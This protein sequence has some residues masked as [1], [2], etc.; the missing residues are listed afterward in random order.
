M[1]LL[2]RL[3]I[4]LSIAEEPSADNALAE[5]KR[6]PNGLLALLSPLHCAPKEPCSLVEVR[7]EVSSAGSHCPVILLFNANVVK[8]QLYCRAPLSAAIV[9]GP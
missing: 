3:S 6:D 4:G 1:K 9:I 5:S 7:A 2:R 8:Y